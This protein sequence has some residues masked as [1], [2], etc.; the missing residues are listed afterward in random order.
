MLPSVATL[1]L[2]LACLATSWGCVQ[3]GMFCV[4]ATHSNGNVRVI[5]DDKNM[6]WACANDTFQ[7]LGFARAETLTRHAMEHAHSALETSFPRHYFPQDHVFSKRPTTYVRF[8][9][10]AHSKDIHNR[11]NLD[12]VA[13]IITSTMAYAVSQLAAANRQVSALSSALTHGPRTRS[14]GANIVPPTSVPARTASTGPPIPDVSVPPAGWTT[15]RVT[16]V[17]RT[18]ARGE[19][20]PESPDGQPEPQ[21]PRASF[22]PVRI[23]D[24]GNEASPGSAYQPRRRRSVSVAPSQRVLRARPALV[25][26]GSAIS[27]P[28]SP[29]A[30]VHQTGTDAPAHASPLDSFDIEED[31]CREVVEEMGLVPEKRPYTNVRLVTSACFRSIK[32]ITACA[33][34]AGHSVV[35]VGPTV[36]EEGG[37]FW[38]WNV[39]LRG[40][41]LMDTQLRALR[42]F[43]M[44][45]TVLLQRQGGTGPNRTWVVSS[46]TGTQQ[47][48]MEL[49][50]ALFQA[51]VP[52]PPVPL[53]YCN[54]NAAQFR[55][56]HPFVTNTTTS[57]DPASPNNG[58]ISSSSV[59][60]LYLVTERD[61]ASLVAHGAGPCCD[62][63]NDSVTFKCR[64]QELGKATVQCKACG[65]LWHRPLFSHQRGTLNRTVWVTSM[66]SGRPAAVERFCLWAHIGSGLP[67]SVASG[68][69]YVQRL[70]SATKLVYMEASQ[71]MIQYAALGDNF[72][73]SLDV[74]HKRMAKGNQEM[75][76]S[77][78]SALSA[79]APELKKPLAF[80]AG[81]R[82]E[83]EKARRQ[84]GD[85]LATMRSVSDEEA[86]VTTSLNGTEHTIFALGTK[87]VEQLVR[88]AW[89]A[90]CASGKIDE[91]PSEMMVKRVVLDAL[92]SAPESCRKAFGA[93]VEIVLDWWH[94]RTQCK[95]FVAKVED[96][97]GSTKGS[98]QFPAFA[99]LKSIIS[100]AFNDAIHAGTDWLT[101]KAD[102]ERQLRFCS[103]N[104]HADD[105]H[106]AAWTHLLTKIEDL[107]SNISLDLGTG[108]NERFHAHL[109]FFVAKGEPVSHE[110]WETCC[111]LAFLSFLDYP[112]WRDRILQLFEASFS[113]QS[114]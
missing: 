106:N 59:G 107:Y 77:K 34:K 75:G 100:P 37:S 57:L 82:E 98:R 95:K 105:A 6:M 68:P 49:V 5:F 39:T 30:V 25:P 40:T 101:F 99:G 33:H 61:L 16:H 109:R 110:H 23:L 112:S 17:N 76:E 86:P 41:T 24:F 58:P 21:R 96:K 81:Q 78:S 19:R 111:M 60:P 67:S 79:C 84:R 7:A 38:S 31:I 56:L 114:Q 27:S 4:V 13:D 28:R 108:I 94:R 8:L 48:C 50:Q 80:V 32:E 69:S 51:P 3:T 44:E 9:V 97:K 83:I 1:F 55:T 62:A 87:I 35:Y 54:P 90:L 103:I 10:L 36:H 91:L 52:A 29:A 20:S 104:V 64:G 22:S 92:S 73:V 63:R 18:R 26:K 42:Y 93:T 12:A 14:S 65:R 11:S 70:Y 72:T 45:V 88:K 53:S 102:L 46:T 89:A 113:K 74:F 15:P 66:L 85:G 71:L 47:E 2:V 43:G